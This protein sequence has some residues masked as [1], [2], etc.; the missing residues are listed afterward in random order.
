MNLGHMNCDMLS[1]KKE[2]SSF[3]HRES[4]KQLDKSNHE[5]ISKVSF[6]P[7]R[8]TESLSDDDDVFDSASTETFL[9]KSI[10]RFNFVN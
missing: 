5:I 2:L 9:T 10:F 1:R 4:A 6:K 3:A 8:S 7:S